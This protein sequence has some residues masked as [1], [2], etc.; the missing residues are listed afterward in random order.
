MKGRIAYEIWAPSAG[1]WSGWVR[2]VQF[3]AIDK[4]EP[5]VHD[6]LSIPKIF[7]ISE[8]KPD[9][10]IIVDLPDKHGVEE[11]LAL[12]KL[13]YL[14]VPLYNGTDPQLGAMAMVDNSKIRA[15]LIWGAT[16]LFKIAIPQN[17][18]P[19][20][21]LDS[22]R[23]YKRRTSSPSFDNGWDL[24]GQDLPTS[25]YLLKNEITKIIVRGRI[26]QKDLSVILYRFQ[27]KGIKIY[28]TE[29][30]KE[31]KEVSIKKPPKK[32]AKFFG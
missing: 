6:D 12:A 32:I 13:G 28:F 17:A 14:P 20:F 23:S 8:L 3:V 18:P 25:D 10:A 29:G 9:A 22:N 26:I 1:I 16:E 19:A 21:L 15:A 7:Y 4:T 2:P 27:Q 31:A 30:Y 24:Y 11:G 5:R